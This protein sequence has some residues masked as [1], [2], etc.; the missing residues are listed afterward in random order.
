MAL[1]VFVLSDGGVFFL[2]CETGVFFVLSDGRF[3]Q[4]INYDNVLGSGGKLAVEFA[5]L[6]RILWSGKHQSYAP[7]NLKVSTPKWQHLRFRCAIVGCYL[8]ADDG[9]L[10]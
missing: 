3:Q 7:S 8:L 5:T 9:H 2:C 1:N 10:R 6:L 4:E